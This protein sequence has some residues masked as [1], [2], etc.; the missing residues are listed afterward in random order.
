MPIEPSP[1]TTHLDG[2]IASSELREAASWFAQNKIWI[3][4]RQLALCRVPAPTFLEEQ[5]AI[6][7]RTQ[8]TALGYQCRID[9]A[10][11]VIA[12]HRLDGKQPVVVVSAHLDTVLSP[13]RP[14]DISLEPDGSFRGPGVADNGSGLS[15]LLAL[16]MVLRPLP[17]WKLPYELLLVANVC[18]E[19]E[20]NL[21]GMRYL[22]QDSDFAA[23]I[24]GVLV[25]DGPGHEHI[26]CRALASRR[27]EVQLQGRGGHSWSDF[28][29]VNP[30]H[31]LSRAISLFAD[32]NAPARHP[33]QDRYSYNVG[34]M[35]GGSSVNSIPQTATAKVD[36]RSDREQVIQELAASLGRCVEQAILKEHELAVRG[37]LT[38]RVREI[39]SR[40]GGRLPDDSPLLA[41]ARA[42][43]QDLGIQT[44]LDTS[45][46]DANI[47]LSMGIPAICIGT[48]G[49]GGGAHT[50]DEWFRP[51]QRDLGLRRVYFIL[52]AMLSGIALPAR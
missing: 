3:Q 21:T 44:Q 37:K 29:T 38:A 48:G 24:A 2:L 30:V 39:G 47:P 49:V 18:E 10:G 8:F 13:R 17:Q 40:P 22:C 34:I 12:G 50:T 7:M 19:G 33:F 15:A 23:R 35:Q 52:T 43:D 42:I 26:T 11:N 16:A 27:F 32:S 51:D 14:E 46:T 25:L 31:A 41:A 4:E 5:R 9:P 45:S 1:L 28:G 20:G 6:H 36:I